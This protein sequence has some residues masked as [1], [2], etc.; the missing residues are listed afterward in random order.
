MKQQYLFLK[1][2]FCWNTLTFSLFFIDVSLLEENLFQSRMTI[3][4]IF[5]VMRTAVWSCYVLG[6]KIQMIHMMKHAY[7]FYIVL[8]LLGTQK[9]L[10]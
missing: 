6:L 5:S 8:I 3:N 9:M 2:Y 10:R 4:M 7:L 1:P